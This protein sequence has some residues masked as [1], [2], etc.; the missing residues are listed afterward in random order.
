MYG[1]EENYENLEAREKAKAEAEAIANG[2][3]FNPYID[4]EKAAVFDSLGDVPFAGD[5]PAAE[6]PAASDIALT[7]AEVAIEGPEAAAAGIGSRCW[8]KSSRRNASG[9]WRANTNRHGRG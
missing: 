3:S 6:A 5:Q 8:T 7:A 1:Q 9:R 4:S 2:E